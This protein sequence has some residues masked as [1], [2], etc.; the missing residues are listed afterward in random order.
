MSEETSVAP[1]AKELIIRHLESMMST[2]EQLNREVP[3]ASV[4][5]ET[6]NW[7]RIQVSPLLF[8][9]L[10]SDIAARYGPE[11]AQ[12]KA[13]ALKAQEAELGDAAKHVTGEEQ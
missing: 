6:Y 12:R 11:H 3:P 5:P 8:M 2:A 10:V 1:S 13:I 9:A 4:P 7:I